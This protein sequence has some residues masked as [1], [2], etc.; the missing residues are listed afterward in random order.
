MATLQSMGPKPDTAQEA[1]LRVLAA[2]IATSY[3]KANTLTPAEL[4]AVISIAYNGLL[5]CTTSK[6]N[7]AVSNPK[8]KSLHRI[9]LKGQ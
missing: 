5:T 7:Q 4:P 9:R 1:A 3:A 6:K 2:K 8:G